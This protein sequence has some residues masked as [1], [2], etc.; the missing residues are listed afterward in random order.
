[1]PLFNPCAPCDGGC[2]PG[3]IP[4]DVFKQAVLEALC[5][6]VNAINGGGLDN[7]FEIQS[8]VTVPFGSVTP[9]YTATGFFNG[10]TQSNFFKVTNNTDTTV[11]VRVGASG[12]TFQLPANGSKQFDSG[13]IAVD[14]I[15]LKY[16]SVAPTLGNV[17]F[18]GAAR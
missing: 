1:M 6:I 15:Y 12:G 18:E 17:L 13:I 3:N 8:L 10:F 7:P 14:N 2:I 16:D 9:G 5:D 11:D 4:N